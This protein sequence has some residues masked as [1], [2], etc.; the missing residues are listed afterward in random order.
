MG[1]HPGA[2]D[3]GTRRLSEDICTMRRI[4]IGNMGPSQSSK[5]FAELTGLKTPRAVLEP[6]AD[7]RN[8]HLSERTTP[9]PTVDPA[10]RPWY[11]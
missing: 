10:L 3:T 5:G 4:P 1:A 6:R 2:T 9:P 7:D 11:P 8:P